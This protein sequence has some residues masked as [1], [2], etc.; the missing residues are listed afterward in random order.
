MKVMGKRET[1]FG[2]A[3]YQFHH[4]TVRVGVKRF[5]VVTWFGCCGYNNLKGE[6]LKVEAEISCPVCHGEMIRS[7]YVGER[8]IAKNVGDVDYVSWFGEDECHSCDYV[9]IVGSRGFG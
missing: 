9:E 1:V 3:F 6:R 8:R 2:T 5:H 4:S 7:A